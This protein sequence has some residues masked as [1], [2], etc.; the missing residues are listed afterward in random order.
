MVETEHLVLRTRNVI[1]LAL[2]K[3]EVAF[4]F[5][6]LTEDSIYGAIVLSILTGV[7]NQLVE[8]RLIVEHGWKR[9]VFSLVRWA[10][11]MTVAYF[12]VI[13]I[14]GWPYTYERNGQL[15]FDIPRVLAVPKIVTAIFLFVVFLRALAVATDSWLASNRE[16]GQG[17]S[18]S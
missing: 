1:V 13:G 15:H 3:A 8:L 5:I 12:C 10:L 7:I 16:K 9:K 18:R 2:L 17:P 4:P 11:V 14:L 6:F